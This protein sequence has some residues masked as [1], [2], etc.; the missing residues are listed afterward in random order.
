MSETV[1]LELPERLHQ[2]LV[3]TAQATQRSLESIILHALTVGSPPDWS[4]V[5]EQY[6]ASLAALDRLDDEALWQTALARKTGKEM[7]RYDELLAKNK[8]GGLTGAE[9][10]ELLDL[11]EA[12]EEFMLHKAHAA[13]ILQWRG[14]RVPVVLVRVPLVRERA[15]LERPIQLS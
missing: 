7:E 6:Q 12:S 11:R 3:N 14:H 2:R 1:T 5:P 8:E 13:A 10:S 4:D 9:Q 15:R